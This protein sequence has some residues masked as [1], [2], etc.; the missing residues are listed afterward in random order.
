MKTE[1]KLD[2]SDDL[3]VGDVVAHFKREISD[4]TK[5][6]MIYLYIIES[7]AE[8]TETGE[9]LVIYKALYSDDKLGVHYGRYARPYDMFISEVDHE[10]YPDIKQK[11][12]FERFENVHTVTTVK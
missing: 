7:I 3:Q 9:K 10:K 8:H 12:R 11:Y 6:P 1:Y 4:T 5:N 2:N